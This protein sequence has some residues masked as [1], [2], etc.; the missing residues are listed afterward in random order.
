MRPTMSRKRQTERERSR[1]AER[2]LPERDGSNEREYCA[3][4]DEPVR[5]SDWHPALARYENGDFEVHLF[6]SADCRES[7][8]V[9]PP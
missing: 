1:S 8:D 6:C 9:D 2:T 5:T 7:W 4:C 3:V